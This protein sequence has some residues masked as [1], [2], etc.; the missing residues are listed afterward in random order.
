MLGLG[1]F[2]N[3]YSLTVNM[4]FDV[5]VA[6]YNL[7]LVIVSFNTYTVQLRID[8]K[9]FIVTTL[10]ESLLSLCKL[11]SESPPKIQPQEPWA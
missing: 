10:K 6:S 2:N 8:L 3:T 11:V 5:T 7:L 9:F 1:C 4:A